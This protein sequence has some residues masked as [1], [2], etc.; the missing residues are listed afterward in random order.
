MRPARFLITWLLLTVLS[1]YV[2]AEPVNTFPYKGYARDCDCKFIEGLSITITV[3]IY[4][5]GPYAPDGTL[6]YEEFHTG[7]LR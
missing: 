2:I 7:F 6:L 1:A 3:G 5:G 4:M